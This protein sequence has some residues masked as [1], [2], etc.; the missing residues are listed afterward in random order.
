MQKKKTN[1]KKLSCFSDISISICCIKLSLLTREDLPSPVNV[2]TNSL[3]ILHT[4]RRGF[5]RLNCLHIGQY[6]CRRC[7]RS[8]FNSVWTHST[9]CLSTGPLRRDFLDN[10]LTRFFGVRNFGNTSP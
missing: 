3:Q 7:C 6:I 2:L 4:T 10:F 5:V 8:D 1:K 9:C